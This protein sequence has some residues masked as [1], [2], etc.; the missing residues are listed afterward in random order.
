MRP[1]FKMQ[2]CSQQSRQWWRWPL[3]EFCQRRHRHC[4]PL[5]HLEL[6]E[7]PPH[8]FLYAHLIRAT[9]ITVFCCHN[10]RQCL[11]R[12]TTTVFSLAQE[13]HFSNWTPSYSNTNSN[14]LQRFPQCKCSLP[15]PYFLDANRLLSISLL[16]G[17]PLYKNIVVFLW[18]DIHFNWDFLLVYNQQP[19]PQLRSS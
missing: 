12:V 14:C 9:K 11:N 16:I 8:R 19:C 5:H 3:S 1:P 6:C 13:L 17:L 18:R 4:S 15:N 10:R 7:K 2:P